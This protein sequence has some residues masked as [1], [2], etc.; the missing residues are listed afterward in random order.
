MADERDM[1]MAGSAKTKIDP[2][3]QKLQVTLAMSFELQMTEKGRAGGSRAAFHY[4]IAVA[5]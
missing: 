5:A 2:G 3:E 4:R 1:A